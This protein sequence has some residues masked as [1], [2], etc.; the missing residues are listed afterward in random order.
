M[1]KKNLDQKVYDTIV[2][3]IE[4]GE[5]V[6]RQRITEAALKK[7]LGISRT[8]IRKALRA[9]AE[10]DYLENI[11]NVGVHVKAMTLDVQGVEERANFLELLVNYYLYNLE[12]EEYEFDGAGLEK[13]IQTMHEEIQERDQAFEQSVFLYFQELLTALEN[14]YMRGAIL[15]AIRE[16]FLIEGPLQEILQ[17]N[18]RPLYEHLIHLADYLAADNYGHARREIRILFNQVKLDVI[19][20]S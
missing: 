16:L 5:L 4:K 2:K 19:E 15:K 17:K 3:R 8:P 20:K 9:L 12:K 18:R 10:D 7:D 11:P 1:A 13:R 6:E 14:N